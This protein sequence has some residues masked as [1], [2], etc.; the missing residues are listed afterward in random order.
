MWL[1]LNPW[2]KLFYR[3]TWLNADRGQEKGII[4]VFIC[5]WWV[6]VETLTQEEGCSRLIR[7]D[8]PSCHKCRKTKQSV[9][10]KPSA[11]KIENGVFT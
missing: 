10:Q 11:I 3:N 7:V 8:G 5:K 4:F 2:E 1:G 6:I 9:L